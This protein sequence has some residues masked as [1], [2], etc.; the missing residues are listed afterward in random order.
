RLPGI[1]M[2]RHYL[3]RIIS[4]AVAL[5]LESSRADLFAVRAA[6]ASAALR[7]SLEVGELD[8]EA[9]VGYVLLPKAR[10]R[11]DR[12]PGEPQPSARNDMN[13][14]EGAHRPLKS[15]HRS[16]SQRQ[17]DS[18]AGGGAAE[19]IAGDWNREVV[20]PPR[21]CPV[22]GGLSDSHRS[23]GDAGKGSTRSGRRI[24][25]MGPAHGRYVGAVPMSRNKKQGAR[26]AIDATLR[27]AAPRQRLRR[28][29]SSSKQMQG[30]GHVACP[31]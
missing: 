31:I 3:A 11:V 9:A 20:T 24:E 19:E 27:A 1:R 7:D 8:M 30:S 18:G 13:R 28:A 15:N 17:A 2:H 14:E 10:P 5:G 22:P 25:R 21:D 12:Q 23:S 16:H 4:T 6:R 26:I 29:A